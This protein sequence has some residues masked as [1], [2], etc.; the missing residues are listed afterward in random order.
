MQ[1]PVV[2]FVFQIHFRKSICILK[3]FVQ[4]IQFS[5]V[6]GIKY[7][8]HIKKVFITTLFIVGHSGTYLGSPYFL[9]CYLNVIFSWL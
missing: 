7:L 6:F 5:K 4:S 8:E 3:V 2:F 9:Y 1:L